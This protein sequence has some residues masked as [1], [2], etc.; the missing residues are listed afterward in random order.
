MTELWMQSNMYPKYYVSS[1]GRVM[2]F[3]KGYN[4][5]EIKS[6]RYDKDGY[7]TIGV[8]TECG[9]NTTA[10]VHRLVADAFI[11]NPNK[12]PVVNHKDNVK[13]NN[14]VS[15]L[16]WTSISYNTSYAYFMGVI[17][18]GNAKKIKATIK[19]KLFSYYDSVVSVANNFDLGR[20]TVEYH[21]NNKQDLFGFI[22]LEEVA[23]IPS[24]SLVNNKLTNYE[25]KKTRHNPYKVGKKYYFNI[26]EFSEINSMSYSKAQRIL[27]EKRIYEGHLVRKCSAEEFYLN[28]GVLNW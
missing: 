16:E 23:N 14:E 3:H 24:G 15:N 8:S 2:H 20:S 13:D 19:G 4:K 26:R 21:V 18:H 10:R 1:I 7:L 22:S 11:P 28:S 9:K 27:N 17:E 6:A 12:C 5:W 25:E